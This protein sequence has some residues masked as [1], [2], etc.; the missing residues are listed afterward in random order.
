MSHFQQPAGGPA[1]GSLSQDRLRPKDALRKPQSFPGWCP[2]PGQVENRSR[3]GRG[4]RKGAPGLPK[5]LDS[6]WLIEGSVAC[7]RP[8]PESC[9]S[10]PPALPGCRCPPGQ[11]VQDG[12]RVPM[13]SCRCGLPSPSASWVL[14]PAEGAGLDCR[15]GVA[16][17]RRP[18]RDAGSSGWEAR[19]GSG[20]RA[21]LGSRGSAHPDSQGSEPFLHTA[22]HSTCVN[23]SLVCRPH[24]CPALG[25][26]SAW[27]SC[28]APCGGAPPRDVAAAR[29]V[30]GGHRARPR[31]R[32]SGRNVTCSPAPV[33]TQG[34][35]CLLFPAVLP[36]PG[37]VPA[38]RQGRQ[39]V[40]RQPP[41]WDTSSL[42]ALPAERP[43]GQVLSPCA[44]S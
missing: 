16:A 18:G 10:S 8:S 11:L 23:G 12:R 43:P 29:K 36:S 9:S 14:A 3:G 33:S 30:L 40:P 39:P 21:L 19:A 35:G 15:A 32:S 44:T 13:S 34:A 41:P 1:R 28:S 7:P 25:P 26:R 6:I 4:G 24:E 31:T 22:A 37:P 5:A 20:L 27:S 42:S 38:D 2:Q 17:R